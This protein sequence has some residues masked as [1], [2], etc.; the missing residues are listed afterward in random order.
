MSVKSLMGSKISKM[1]KNYTFEVACI[2]LFTKC[3][4][5]ETKS[6]DQIVTFPSSFSSWTDVG[7]LGY[8]EY[9]GNCHSGSTHTG[10]FSN[11]CC[12]NKVTTLRGTWCLKK[13]IGKCFSTMHQ[14]RL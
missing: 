9:N 2:I 14:Y 13:N 12:P 3:W 7:N 4:K 11:S 10:Y 6:V 5:V 1:V 8:P